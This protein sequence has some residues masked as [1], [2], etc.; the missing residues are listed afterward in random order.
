MWMR[1]A[2]ARHIKIDTM[3]ARLEPVAVHTAPGDERPA[4][5]DKM[6]AGPWGK[7]AGIRPP[8]ASEA[9]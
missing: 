4:S 8:S 6:S 7:A 9:M 5:T 2:S 1:G 3:R